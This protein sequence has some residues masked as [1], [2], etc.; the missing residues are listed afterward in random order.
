MK[1]EFPIVNNKLAF[2][3]FDRTMVA[4]TYSADYV[5]A[6]ENNY[7]MECVYNLTVQEEEHAND[8]PLP[9]MQWYVKKLFD[10]GYGIYCLTHEI[11]NLRDQMKQEELKAFYPDIPMTYLTVDTPEHKIDMMKAVAMVE[12]CD[13]SDVIFVDDLM[14]TVYQ[15]LLAGI[16]A[17]HLSDI[18]VMYEMQLLHQEQGVAIKPVDLN[19]EDIQIS[20]ESSHETVS[21]QAAETDMG[22]SK[23]EMEQIFRECHK[24]VEKKAHPDL[25]NPD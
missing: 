20:N 24:E 8:R 9:C 16:D 10:E 21:D 22:I 14:S 3:D 23:L 18:V 19:G 13:L 7:F 25:T 15:A 2:I 6:E 1:V 5:K 17:K 4:H 11:F 12:C